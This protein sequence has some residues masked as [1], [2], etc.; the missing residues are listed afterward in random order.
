MPHIVSD[1]LKRLHDNGTCCDSVNRDL[2]VD[3]DNFG[4][5]AFAYSGGYHDQRA[6]TVCYRA[7]EDGLISALLIHNDRDEVERVMESLIPLNNRARE[8]MVNVY[9][10]LCRST[11]M[12]YAERF[13]AFSLLRDRLQATVDK[14]PEPIIDPL[15]IARFA[16]GTAANDA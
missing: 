16:A 4:M 12:T 1:I 8:D 14:E 6:M 15:A 10:L 9:A 13:T 7:N 5:A 11:A 3:A 2:A